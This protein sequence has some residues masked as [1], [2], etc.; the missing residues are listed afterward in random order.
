MEISTVLVE[1][2]CYLFQE[3][4]IDN[5]CRVEIGYANETASVSVRID[6][7]N[8]G[9]LK[10]IKFKYKDEHWLG[11]IEKTELMKVNCNQW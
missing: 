5:C 4:P 10:Y 3:V 7:I 6:L 11:L 9:D 2:T 8:K 1:N